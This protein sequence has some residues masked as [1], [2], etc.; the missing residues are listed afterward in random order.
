ML[1]GPW[2]DDM[3]ARQQICTRWPINYAEAAGADPVRQE[4]EDLV[5]TAEDR[6]RSRVC[7]DDASIRLHCASN[8]KDADFV[9]QTNRRRPLEQLDDLHPMFGYH[10]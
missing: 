10:R 8:L 2:Q 5:S 6:H 4:E 7:D 3:W 1:D 9:W